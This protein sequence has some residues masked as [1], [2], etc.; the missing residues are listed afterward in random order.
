MDRLLN[1]QVVIF[2]APNLSTLSAT[3]VHTAEPLRR[4][5][6]N[7]SGSTSKTA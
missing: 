2:S 3:S 7:F 4:L 6:Q 5:S 1:P